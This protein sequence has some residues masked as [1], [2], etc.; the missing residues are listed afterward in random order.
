MTDTQVRKAV[1][2]LA[3]RTQD[4][5]LMWRLEK[6]PSWLQHGTDA[7]VTICYE[8]SFEGRF[9]RLYES[10][11]RGYDENLNPIGWYSTFVLEI[12]DQERRTLFTFPRVSTLNELWE[13]VQSQTS[14]AA[15]LVGSLT[16]SLP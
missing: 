7:L 12:T 10:S 11:E 16:G 3:K 13:A 9:L 2:E 1:A 4:R 8:T 5:Q 6:P 14:G 15:E